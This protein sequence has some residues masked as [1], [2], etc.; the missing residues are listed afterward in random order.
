MAKGYELKCIVPGCNF[1]T[2]DSTQVGLLQKILGHV[3]SA[4]NMHEVDV[5][6]L[7]KLRAAIRATA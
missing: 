5:D 3:S 2:T 6:T 4:H 7:I 1:K